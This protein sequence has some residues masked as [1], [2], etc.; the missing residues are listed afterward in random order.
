MQPPIYLPLEHGSLWVSC[1][2]LPLLGAEE[3][4]PNSAWLPWPLLQNR[5]CCWASYAISISTSTYTLETKSC[6]CHYSYSLSLLDSI[7]EVRESF[8]PND[9][10]DL[11]LNILWILEHVEHHEFYR[12]RRRVASGEEQ[13]T[14]AYY[15]ILVWNEEFVLFLTLILRNQFNSIVFIEA[16]IFLPRNRRW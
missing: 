13:V 6:D 11:S 7:L 14:T 3:D 12:V 1:P 4:R 9:L 5:A 2:Q 8:W 10:V 16:D 15:Q